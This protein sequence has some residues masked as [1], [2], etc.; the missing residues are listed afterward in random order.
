[1]NINQ[2]MNLLFYPNKQRTKNNKTPVYV[3]IYIDGMRAEFTTP[4]LIEEKNWDSKHGKVKPVD[5]EGNLPFFLN[6]IDE[7]LQL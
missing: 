1:M 5:I 2:K 4:H 7:H 3:R 6:F